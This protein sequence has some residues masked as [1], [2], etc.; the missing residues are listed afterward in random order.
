MPPEEEQ[1]RICKE[2]LETD[3]VVEQLEK[4][5]THK[6]KLLNKLKSAEEYEKLLVEKLEERKRAGN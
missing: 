3:F 1:V 2:F 5:R 4:V 6:E